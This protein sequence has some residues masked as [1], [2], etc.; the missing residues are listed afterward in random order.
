M[1]I[2]FDIAVVAIVI[3][4]VFLGYHRGFVRTVFNLIGYILAAVLAYFI[5]SPLAT[6]IFQTFFRNSV[7]ELINGELAKATQGMDINQM[8][9]Q[10]IA[11]IPEN[12]RAF[13]PENALATVENSLSSVPTTAE[14]ANTVVDQL[15]G[16]IASL[17]IQGLLFVVLFILLCI[18]VKLV[19]R[20]LKFI[21]KI[22]FVGTANS[23]LG[24]VVG[25]AEAV[26]FVFFFTSIVA[27]LITLSGDQWSAVNQSVVDQSYIFRFIYEYNPLTKIN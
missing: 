18:V 14:V 22:P 26:V 2:I 1:S 21:D 4:L 27:M 5:S 19:T 7:V 20:M 15:V 23:V 9:Q 12:F 17:A 16:P 6:W 24:L 11:S 13:V 25:L 3:L 8:V 10:A